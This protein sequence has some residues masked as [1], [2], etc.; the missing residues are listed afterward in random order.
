MKNLLLLIIFVVLGIAQATFLDGFRLLGLKPDLLIICAIISGLVFNFDFKWLIAGAFLSGVL[1][2][3]LGVNYFGLNIILFV[4]IAL[5]VARLSKEITLD[6]TLVQMALTFCVCLLYNFVYLIIGAYL[7]N[8]VSLGMSFRV[9]LPGSVY[10]A[11]FFPV[12]FI[13]VTGLGFEKADL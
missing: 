10:T 6:T 1:K 3:I 8:F 2:D 9:I 12:I 5:A 7:G 4:F 13:A 11:L